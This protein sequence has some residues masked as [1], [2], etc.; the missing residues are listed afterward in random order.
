MTIDAS[1][2]REVAWMLAPLKRAPDMEARLDTEALRGET[3]AVGD[4]RDGWVEARLLGDG[5]EGW[6]PVAALMGL[7]PAPTH[8][9]AVPR[10][11]GFRG[12]EIKDPPIV[13]LTLGARVRVTRSEGRFAVT[14]EGEH[15]IA[16][17][18]TP[19]GTRV[20]D[21]VETAEAHARTPYLWGGKSANGI[22]CSGLLQL[23][24][25]SANV[26]APRDSG[27]QERGLGLALP[28]GTDPVTLRR[29][30]LIFWK[31][32]VAIARG[33]G[34][35]IHANAHHMAVAIEPIAEGIARIAAS[36]SPVTRCK[37]VA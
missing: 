4:G 6:L 7:R 34:T 17:H 11:L 23:A 5:Y 15:L 3:V 31:G 33:D 16:D 21:W 10:T 27:P 13:A 26:A 25:S 24:L 28:D 8:V 37:R 20:R 1:Q 9:V 18:L 22:D 12:P 32:H 29:G 19:V 36:G 30:D 35:M 14:D 2:L